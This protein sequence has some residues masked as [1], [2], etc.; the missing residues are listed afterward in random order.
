VIANSNKRGK[1]SRLTWPTVFLSLL[2]LVQCQTSVVN[3][4][5]P[6]V[7]DEPTA[8]V[9]QRYGSV[10]AGLIPVSSP[11]EHSCDQNPRRVVITRDWIDFAIH[12]WV[13][14]I[15]TTRTVELYCASPNWP[16]NPK[17]SSRK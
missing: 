16:T 8:A 9:D 11:A 15:Y 12:F 5:Q 13:G 10:I 17:R 6:G 4:G 3:F 1:L 7:G 2:F 14:G